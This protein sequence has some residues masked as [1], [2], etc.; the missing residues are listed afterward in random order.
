[1]IGEVWDSVEGTTGVT[2][3]LGMIGIG[4]LPR[5]FLNR[6]IDV[7]VWLKNKLNC[8]KLLFFKFTFHF[9]IYISLKK[10]YFFFLK[11]YIFTII[12]ANL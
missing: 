8:L 12:D 4:D 3:V 9:K 1:M 6:F 2:L 7:Y 10:Y 5:M 11:I